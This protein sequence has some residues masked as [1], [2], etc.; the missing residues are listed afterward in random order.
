MW[1]TPNKMLA[2]RKYLHDRIGMEDLIMYGPKLRMSDDATV[3][4]IV[5]FA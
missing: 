2:I 4:N 3:A 5:L 1:G